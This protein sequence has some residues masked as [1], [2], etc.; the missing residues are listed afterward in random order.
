MMIYFR[1]SQE[2]NQTSVT[3]INSHHPRYQG[4]EMKLCKRFYIINI[5]ILSFSFQCHT[6]LLS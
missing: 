6:L 1:S 5:S 2:I 3:E 4:D